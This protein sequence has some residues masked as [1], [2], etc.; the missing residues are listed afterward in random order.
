[1]CNVKKKVKSPCLFPS[2]SRL[3]GLC[4]GLKCANIKPRSQR[5]YVVYHHRELQLPMARDGNQSTTRYRPK[6]A[7]HTRDIIMELGEFCNLFV[8]F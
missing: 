3:E 1:M 6:S 8:V 7:I 4:K 5:Q 2:K